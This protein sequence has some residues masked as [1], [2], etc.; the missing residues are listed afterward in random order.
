M[1]QKQQVFENKCFFVVSRCK[2]RRILYLRRYSKE[3]TIA[4][5]AFGK[6]GLLNNRKEVLV[7]MDCVFDYVF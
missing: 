2:N 5:A 7:R 1:L 6:N 3:K 4:I